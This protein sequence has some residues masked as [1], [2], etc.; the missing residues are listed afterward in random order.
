[1]KSILPFVAFFSLVLG[2]VVTPSVARA[3]TATHVET[4]ALPANVDVKAVRE[5]VVMS[6]MG[7]AW[8]VKEQDDS[9]AVGYL[10]H[11]GNEAEVTFTFDAKTI[12]ISCWGYEIRKDGTRVKPEL[13]AGWL[14]NLSKDIRKRLH[15][16]AK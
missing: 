11:R 10:K 15:L 2:L 8:S 3:E 12:E 6:L 4:I 7:R 9:H 14:N 5:A 16:G 1:M 13:P